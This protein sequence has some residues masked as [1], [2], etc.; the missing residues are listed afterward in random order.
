MNF[1]EYRR[2]HFRKIQKRIALVCWAG[3]LL[4]IAVQLGIFFMYLTQGFWEKGLIDYPISVY[5]WR[6]VIRPDIFI[7]I[8]STGCTWV[9]YSERFSEK[10]R[11]YTACFSV[12]VSCTSI[13]ICNV[14]F[15]TVMYLITFPIFTSMIFGDRKILRIVSLVN[16]IPFILTAIAF[17]MKRPDLDPTHRNISV[18][19]LG[20]LLLVS[21]IVCAALS[22]TQEIQFQYIYSNYKKQRI[23]I[24]ELKIEPMTQLYNKTALDGCMN[25]YRRK[26]IAGEYKPSVV[27]LDIDHFKQVNDTYGHAAGDEVLIA[28]ANIIKDRMQ[29]RRHAFRFG[30][31]EFVLAFETED[32]DFVQNRVQKIKDDFCSATFAFAPGRNF[33][34]SAGISVLKDGMEKTDWFNAADAALYKAKETGRN[35][36]EVAG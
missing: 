14:Y 18:L 15:Y 17:N 31:E 12:M 21:Y 13:A 3:A 4:S 28:L 8:A 36:I 34:F 2:S 23:L 30:G 19:V 27:I 16:I 6:G 1:E 22:K 9:S 25:A 11:N 33:S 20:A 35:K 24:E 29:G 7:I 10:V 32:L 5:L 26:Y